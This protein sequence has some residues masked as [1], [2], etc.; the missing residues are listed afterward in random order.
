MKCWELYRSKPLEK[1][2]LDSA[3]AKKPAKGKKKVRLDLP[4]DAWFGPLFGS[5]NHLLGAHFRPKLLAFDAWLFQ[6]RLLATFF[7]LIF[8]VK[9]GAKK[10]KKGDDDDI[11]EFVTPKFKECVQKISSSIRPLFLPLFHRRPV[12]FGCI[13][14]RGAAV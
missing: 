14:L 9:S 12:H 7:E 4:F 11:I 6:D 13:W 5:F 10:G 1:G 8:G 3:A 2:F